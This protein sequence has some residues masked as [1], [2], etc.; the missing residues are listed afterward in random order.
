MHIF[1]YKQLYNIY[2][3][4][5]K[6]ITYISVYTYIYIY[7]FTS[8][9]VIFILPEKFFSG[10]S[11]EIDHISDDMVEINKLSGDLLSNIK[12]LFYSSFVQ[13]RK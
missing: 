11:F 5:D 8:T 6:Y 9:C 1:V 12:K 4:S 3:H 7:L 10:R 13:W 2:L